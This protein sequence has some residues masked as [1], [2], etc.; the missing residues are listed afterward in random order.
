MTLN[1]VITQFVAITMQYPSEDFTFW[2]NHLLESRY[3]K[4]ESGTR[5]SL[6]RNRLDAIES[7]DDIREQSYSI[8]APFDYKSK[9]TLPSLILLCL[10]IEGNSSVRDLE[11]IR[12]MYPRIEDEVR[13]QG[14]SKYC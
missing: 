1:S 7:I 9:Q 8:V 6:Y 3:P 10:M 11:K 5:V 13:R 12:T 4:I 2:S 14:F